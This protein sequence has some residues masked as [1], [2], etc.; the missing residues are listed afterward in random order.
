MLNSPQPNQC[1][2]GSLNGIGNIQNKVK[3]IITM[4]YQGNLI[5]PTMI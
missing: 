1:L 3:V 4:T 2:E 5:G